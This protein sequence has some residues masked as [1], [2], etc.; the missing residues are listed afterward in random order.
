MSLCPHRETP[1][2]ALWSR[3]LFE[4][5]MSP[6]IARCGEM[7]IESNG[8]IIASLTGSLTLS[9]STLASTWTAPVDFIF[10]CHLHTQ[11]KPQTHGCAHH[12]CTLHLLGI[13]LCWVD[14]IAPCSR[15][16]KWEHLT[17]LDDLHLLF[18]NFDGDFDIKQGKCLW[19][20]DY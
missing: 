15:R 17:H 9:W 2:F 8:I 12:G 1:P 7:I 20:R 16:L 6:T 5:L 11:Q 19:W 13:A 3:L 10:S 14:R 4:W 18:S